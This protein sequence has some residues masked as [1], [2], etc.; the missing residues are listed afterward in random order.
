MIPLLYSNTSTIRN[1]E[2]MAQLWPS[3]YGMR[4]GDLI[5]H[6]VQSPNTFGM[7]NLAS[8]SGQTPSSNSQPSHDDMLKSFFGQP[9]RAIQR[10]PEDDRYGI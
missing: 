5:P 4:T 8:S 9:K 2:K 7:Y 1:P 6:M 10:D 3:G